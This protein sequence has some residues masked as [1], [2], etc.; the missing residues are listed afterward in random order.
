MASA[1][2]ALLR[3]VDSRPLNL[4][5]S[6]DAE[7]E[8]AFGDC[9]KDDLDAARRATVLTN[10]TPL[11]AAG[12]VHRVLASAENHAAVETLELDNGLVTVG[13]GLVAYVVDTT[14]RAI[15]NWNP[16]V[17]TGGAAEAGKFEALT[18]AADR[19]TWLPEPQSSVVKLTLR[20]ALAPND[21]SS[22]A[23]LPST[24]DILA[25]WAEGG[26]AAAPALEAWLSLAPLDVADLTAVGKSFAAVQPSG[27]L[28]DAL[29]RATA[30]LSKAIKLGALQNL[31]ADP[32]AAMPS[33][34]VLVALGA[35]IRP[36]GRSW[37]HA[38]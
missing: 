12:L 11:V 27:S 23:A 17:P 26:A 34:T 5:P 33:R 31:L 1:A 38:H 13:P 8:T 29:S 24:A 36:L 9:A 7:V 32:S 25:L 20:A 28:L 22:L 10:A 4:R 16:T 19:C 3:L 14:A 21:D 6:L 30:R 18:A 35:P 15:T 37:A 2:T